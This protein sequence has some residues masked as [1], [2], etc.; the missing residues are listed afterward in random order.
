MNGAPLKNGP[1]LRVGIVTI[2]CRANQADS[3]RMASSL[4]PGSVE[5]DCWTEPCD[6]VLINTCSVTSRAEADAR[7]LIRRAR[8]KHPDAEIIV[9]G[10]AV[11]VDPDR[12]SSIP[13]VDTIVGLN[14]RD[15]IGE[16]L[17]E[18]PGTVEGSIDPPSGGV[19]GPTPLR[20]HRSRPF[21]KIQDGCSRGCT[22]C[23]VP[24]AR[25]IERSRKP[26]Q[27]LEDIR[28][29]SEAGYREIVFTGVHLGRWGRDLG[30]NLN[31]LLDILDNVTENV[32][33]RLSSLEPMDLTP[34]LV[35]RI[36]SHPKICP[37]LHF[38]LQ[39]G[40]QEI[41]NAM[42][43]GH[44]LD[45]YRKLLEAAVSTDPDTS[46]GTDVMVGFPGETDETHRNTVD[47]LNS[48]PLT[49][50]H[51]F[52]FSPRDGTIAA[53]MSGRPQGKDVKS[54]LNDLK[55]L[56]K[57][58][59]QKFLDSQA[60]TEREFILESPPHAS[61]RRIAL[62]DNYVRMFVSDKISESLIEDFIHLLIDTISDVEG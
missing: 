25:G 1:A 43:R 19:D 7:K 32:R 56:D 26:D 45:D 2:G 44:S 13:E 18:H 10:C 22:Y 57:S 5:V 21:L 46:L 15:L 4:P 42:G 47:F 16:I 36:I 17:R 11:Q 33:I 53:R 27:I 39:S 59:R 55:K 60:G 48:L 52:S 30:T 28:L 37:H 61:G 12:W 58:I 29:L 20:G 34:G 54:R 3:A 50:L 31:E 9:T 38:P 40:D 23:I 6:T 8:R 24:K 14:G 49:Y 35:E 41:L 62:S 51:I